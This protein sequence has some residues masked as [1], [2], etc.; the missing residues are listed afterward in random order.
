MIIPSRTEIQGGEAAGT[1]VSSKQRSG[2]ERGSE[3]K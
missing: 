2:H 1:E 3:V